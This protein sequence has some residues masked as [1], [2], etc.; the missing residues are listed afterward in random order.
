MTKP[1]ATIRVLTSLGE[2]ARS[3]WDACANPDWDGDVP[4]ANATKRVDNSFESNCEDAP[5]ALTTTAARLA[6]NPFLSHDFLGA[7]EESGTATRKTGW[8]AQHLVIDDAEG[9]AAAILP[10]YLKSHSMGEYVFDHG[11]AEAFERAGGRYYPKLQVSVPFTPVTGRRLLARPGHDDDRRRLMLAEGA[12]ALA[13]RRTASSIHVTFTTE[14][15]SELLGAAGYLRRTD[16]QFHFVNEGY[17]DFDDFL[18]ALASRKRKTIKRE[19]REALAGGI[20]V[21]QLTGRD[22]TEAAW[23]AFFAF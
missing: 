21:V 23:D 9:K 13:E 14:A 3:D 19:R 10:C 2:I 17:R 15:E 22:L 11:W 7:L 5:N 16:Q 1:N 18:A 12:I 6:Y 4:F 20:E 8:F